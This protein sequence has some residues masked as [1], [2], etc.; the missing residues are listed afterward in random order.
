[1]RSA[2]LGTADVLVVMDVRGLT[3]TVYDLD[4]VDGPGGVVLCSLHLDRLKAPR[5]WT[6]V[7]ARTG[8][9]LIPLPERPM[10]TDEA[11]DEVIRPIADVSPLRPVT[12]AIHPL[13]SARSARSRSRSRSRS[14]NTPTVAPSPLETPLL[15]RAF[16]G[17]DRH[18]ATP[19]RKASVVEAPVEDQPWDQDWDQRDPDEA[20][21]ARSDEQLVFGSDPGA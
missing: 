20:T 12:A 10:T 8:G 16:L 4:E 19:R 11:A 15:A 3:F 18:P 1:M 17:V 5:G 9:N 2:C 14:R 6:L 21:A 13:E 7:D